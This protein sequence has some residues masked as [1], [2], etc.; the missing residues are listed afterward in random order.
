M[1]LLYWA[2][3]YNTHASKNERMQPHTRVVRSINDSPTLQSASILRCLFMPQQFRP[4]NQI[5]QQKE[6]RQVGVFPI[7]L[8]FPDVPLLYS[9]LR[10]G[11]AKFTP[12][13]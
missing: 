4:N 9:K 8:I 7:V 2:N 13:S 6:Q 11:N 1:L 3:Q 5:P 10:K 12:D